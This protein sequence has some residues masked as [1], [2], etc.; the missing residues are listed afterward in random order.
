MQAIK[1]KF[2]N[3]PL[4]EEKLEDLDSNLRMAQ[5]RKLTPGEVWYFLVTEFDNGNYRLR[6][7]N[8]EKM[9]KTYNFSGEI[10]HAFVEVFRKTQ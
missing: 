9:Y 4:I 1:I 6:T 3:F 5:L 7:L 2:D 8:R 10:E